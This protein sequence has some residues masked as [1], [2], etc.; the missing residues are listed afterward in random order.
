MTSLPIGST[1]DQFRPA[2]TL[3]A[4]KLQAIFRKRTATAK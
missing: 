2:A 3:T 4:E 1:Y